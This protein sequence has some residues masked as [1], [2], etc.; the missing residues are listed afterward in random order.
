MVIREIILN[1]YLEE[2]KEKKKKDCEV[3]DWLNLKY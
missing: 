1:W 3:A 2:V